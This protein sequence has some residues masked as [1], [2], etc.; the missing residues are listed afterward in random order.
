MLDRIIQ[1]SISN[2]LIIGMFTLALAIWGLTGALRLP[3]DAVPDI[4]NNQVQIITYS[5]SLSP[6]EVEQLI[7]F[8]VELN[9]ANIPHIVEVRSISRF[10]LSVVTAVFTDNTDIY[11]ARQQVS[12]RLKTASEQIPKG[13]GIPELG[14]VS[15]RTERNLSVH[16]S[17]QKGI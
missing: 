4:T 7:T 11:W 16:H 13:L 3:I 5:P 15:T 12:E 2:K 14:P 6:Q 9:M 8:P 1:F 17:P 10:G